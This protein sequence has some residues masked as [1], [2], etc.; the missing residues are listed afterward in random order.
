MT[1]NQIEASRRLLEYLDRE[2]RR[3]PYGSISQMEAAVAGIT[4]TR[5][6]WQHRVKKGY[7]NTA[8]LFGIFEFL[9][10]N[11]V[12]FLRQVFGSEDGIDL[13]L[14]KG[15]EPEIV[16]RAWRRFRST[17]EQDESPSGGEIPKIIDRMRYDKPQEAIDL[18]LR[19]VDYCPRDMLPR[20]LGAAG[21]SWRLMVQLSSAQHAIY[22]AI[23]MSRE[24]NDGNLLGEMLQR[25]AYVYFEST[26]LKSALEFSRKATDVYFRCGNTVGVG[27]SLV[28]QGIWLRNLGQWKQAITIQ[29]MALEWLPPEEHYNRYAA[30]YYIAMDSRELRD[31][32]Q[33]LEYLRKAEAELETLPEIE[34]YKMNCLRGLI[35]ADLGNLEQAAT[36]I[37]EAVDG[38]AR[39]HL[40]TMALAL[41]ELVEIEV[42]RRNSKGAFQ[43]ACKLQLLI[44]PLN[45]NKIASAAIADLLRDGEAGLNGAIARRTH[46][47]LKGELQRRQVWRRLESAPANG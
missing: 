24:L 27:K 40:G 6:W 3:L 46:L 30:F 45:D 42:R 15:E 12:R 4:N 18:A 34:R 38:F 33:A 25:M 2:V 44:E 29:K 39:L 8:Q 47:K 20:L 7:V 28:D 31:S 11:P 21:S 37:S 23:Q 5:G 9:G 35:W 26:E 43:A 16:Q 1:E 19:I 10:L 41:C 36:L 14:P 17:T 22:S 32:E 13:D